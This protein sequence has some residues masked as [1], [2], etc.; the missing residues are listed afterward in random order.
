[1]IKLFRSTVLVFFTLLI[2]MS[3]ARSWSWPPENNTDCVWMSYEVYRCYDLC[4]VGT[5]LFTHKDSSQLFADNDVCPAYY[6]GGASCL[7]AKKLLQEY[8]LYVPAQG[9]EVS[10]WRGGLLLPSRTI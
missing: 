6:K 8:C 7:D 3:D 5:F 4:A 10:T 1:M 9:P 2:L